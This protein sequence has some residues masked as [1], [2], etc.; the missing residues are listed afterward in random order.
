MSGG[1]HLPTSFPTSAT[2]FPAVGFGTF[3]GDAGN[4]SVKE[5]VLQALRCGYRHIDTAT[6]YGNE[7]E[8]GEAIRESGIS[9]EDI[10]VTTKLAQTWHCDSDVERALDLSLERLQ[11]D[12]AIKFPMHT[13]LDR[14]TTQ[15][16]ILMER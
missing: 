12:Y 2:T 8:V 1:N 10:F 7:R 5:A 15:S 13:V 6:A 4:G 9:R 14:I 11:L 3:Q 16:V